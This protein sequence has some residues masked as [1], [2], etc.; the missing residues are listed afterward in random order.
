MSHDGSGTTSDRGAAVR[1]CPAWG[2]P[3]SFRSSGRTPLF[4]ASGSSGSQIDPTEN[5]CLACANRG[6][7]ERPWQNRWTQDGTETKSLGCRS[8]TL[9]STVL[10]E[11]DKWIDLNELQLIECSLSIHSIQFVDLHGHALKVPELSEPSPNVS[12]PQ[13]FQPLQWPSW[14]VPDWI[15]HGITLGTRWCPVVRNFGLSLG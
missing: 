7:I 2:N 9:S 15:A 13:W 8:S 11:I 10:D 1:Q 6:E 5:Y 3:G 14:Y 12:P 4:S